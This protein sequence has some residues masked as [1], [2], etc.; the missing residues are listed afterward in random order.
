[1]F[2]AGFCLLGM[3]KETNNLSKNFFKKYIANCI[4][5]YTINQGNLEIVVYVAAENYNLKMVK[6]HHRN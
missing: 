1:M 5:M 2:F 6:Y 4:L 3:D